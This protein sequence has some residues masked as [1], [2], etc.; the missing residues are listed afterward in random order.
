MTSLTRRHA[1]ALPGLA[2]LAACAPSSEPAASGTELAVL[3]DL[4]LGALVVK[5][6]VVLKRTSDTEVLAFT[7]VCTHTGCTVGTSGDGLLCPC[8][9]SAYD[10]SG[11]V[12]NG[13]AAED[14]AAVA[15]TV[16]DGKV[17]TA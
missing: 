3:A 6:K 17:L 14:L 7:A 10:A 8:H 5:D 12:T 13:P 15:V 4:P 9:G 1:L 16:Q 2:C 11:K